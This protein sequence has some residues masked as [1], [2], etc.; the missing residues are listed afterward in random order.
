MNDQLLWS[1]HVL[2]IWWADK[3]DRCH[4]L[5]GLVR[6]V[7]NRSA[8]YLVLIDFVGIHTWFWSWVLARGLYSLFSSIRSE[9]DLE[10]FATLS[11]CFCSTYIIYS[12]M[13][14]KRNRYCTHIFM[15]ILCST[16]VSWNMTIRMNKYKSHV[17][18]QHIK[19]IFDHLNKNTYEMLIVT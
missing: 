5:N 18:I 9:S 14:W 19:L 1:G 6:F 2:I 17:M 11:L 8:P 7:H 4:S 16:F 13:T 3:N 12:L 10:I 15:F